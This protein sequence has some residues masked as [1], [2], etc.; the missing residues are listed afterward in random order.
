MLKILG[1]KV[2]GFLAFLVLLVAGVGYSLVTFVVPMREQAERELSAL[3]GEIETRRSEVARLKE[4][5]VL[6]QFQ[7][8]EFKELEVSGF[9]NDQNRVAAQDSF[10]SLRNMSG[11]LKAKYSIKSGEKV[12]DPRAVEAGQIVLKSPVALDVDSLDD[13][14]V[15][16][17][18]KLI[19]E[20]FPGSVDIT[21]F[22][23]ARTENLNVAT[24][25]QIGSGVPMV[26]VRG[27]VEFDWRTMSPKD[28]ISPEEASGEKA[29]SGM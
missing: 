20:R 22:S 5:Y 24:L 19:Q 6:L 3:N 2:A 15:Y 26:L 12:E 29:S 27:K 11:L 17:F 1:H 7:V 13:V 18:V 8:R 16:S 28:E 25:R 4:E 21:K 14:D 9:F 23:V 10:E